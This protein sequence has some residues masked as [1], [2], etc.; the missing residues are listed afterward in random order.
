MSL[1]AKMVASF[2]DTQLRAMRPTAENQA[3]TS[4]ALGPSRGSRPEVTPP[5]LITGGYTL[6]SQAGSTGTT[7]ILSLPSP[8][9]S[10]LIK[11]V[12]SLL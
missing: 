11:S 6:K 4:A 5:P 7:A 8:A 9:A 2:S 12:S 10:F 1:V 3:T